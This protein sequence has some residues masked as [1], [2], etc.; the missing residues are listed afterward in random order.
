[1]DVFDLSFDEWERT[2]PGRI[3]AAWVSTFSWACSGGKWK[4]CY[5]MW[6]LEQTAWQARHQRRLSITR[7]WYQLRKRELLTCVNCHGWSKPGWSLNFQRLI[8]ALHNWQDPPF[9]STSIDE[10]WV[11]RSHSRERSPLLFISKTRKK[12]KYSLVQG[13]TSF[14][15]SKVINAQYT[16][17]KY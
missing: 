1:M 6:H 4:H 2:S 15:Y 5:L 10:I 13:W 16:F 17:N 9:F 14:I 8:I 12:D 3:G 11:L 7:V